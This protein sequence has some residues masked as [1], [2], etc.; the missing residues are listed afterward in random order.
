MVQPKKQVTIDN[1]WFS[2]NQ[3]DKFL[4]NNT[5]IV[6][7]KNRLTIIR[8]YNIQIMKKN[9]QKDIDEIWPT[10]NLLNASFIASIVFV[11]ESHWVLYFNN[12]KEAYYIDPLR[13]TFCEKEV[14]KQCDFVHHII[15]NHNIKYGLPIQK[16]IDYPK[17]REFQKNNDDC[18]PMACGYLINLLQ[19]KNLQ[20]INTKNIR[21]WVWTNAYE[22]TSITSS[23]GAS[24]TNPNPQQSCLN[25][26][27]QNTNT[28]KINPNSQ[29]INTN[30]INLNSKMINSNPQKINLNSKEEACSDSSEENSESLGN[31]LQNSSNYPIRENPHIRDMHPIMEKLLEDPYD[32]HFNMMNNIILHNI[33]NL[34]NDRGYATAALLEDLKQNLDELKEDSPYPKYVEKRNHM[35]DEHFNDLIHIFNKKP[36]MLPLSTMERIYHLPS[37]YG[38]DFD[39]FYEN[40]RTILNSKSGKPNLN[41]ETVEEL[42]NF[43]PDNHYEEST[44]SYTTDNDEDSSYDS[45]EYL[46]Q[47]YEDEYQRYPV[48]EEE[49]QGYEDWY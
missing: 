6:E 36:D 46:K 15:Q 17:V 7:N 43:T 4:D 49:Y 20:K 21:E 23:G 22:T 42:T 19:R 27:I 37:K 39:K 10:N 12:K 5:T 32:T 34:H 11:N 41:I 8:S 13:N 31:I 2:D 25:Q 18:G 24:T 14:K 3:I 47:E 44:S 9:D 35:I 45:E 29:E 1:F 48:Y 28:L 16:V 40:I 33:S 30:E 38:M 26:Y